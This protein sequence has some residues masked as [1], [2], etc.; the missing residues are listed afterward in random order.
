MDPSGVHHTLPSGSLANTWPSDAY[1]NPK[2]PGELSTPEIADIMAN[3][4][5][6]GYP[7]EINQRVQYTANNEIHKVTGSK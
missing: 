1:G 5:N 3:I 4:D 7:G 6:D 2:T